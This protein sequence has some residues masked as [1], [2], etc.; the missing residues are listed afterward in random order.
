MGAGR[1]VLAGRIPGYRLGIHG[2]TQVYTSFFQPHHWRELSASFCAALS[3]PDFPGT[4]ARSISESAV[5][6]SDRLHLSHVPLW[7]NAG[8]S[9]ACLAHTGGYALRTTT[10]GSNAAGAVSEA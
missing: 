9:D 10:C 4:F 3:P 6:H 2:R 7:L 1:F 8:L 5:P